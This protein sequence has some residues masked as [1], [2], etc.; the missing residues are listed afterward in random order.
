MTH[1]PAPLRTRFARATTQLERVVAQYREAFG[2]L[3]IGS[4]EDH[5]GI[6]GVILAFPGETTQYEW[7]ATQKDPSQGQPHPD[8]LLVWYFEHQVDLD[9]WAENALA[10][11]FREVM[12]HNPYWDRWGRTLEDVDGYRVVLALPPR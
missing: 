4:F 3:E 8:D 11:G 2:L 10:V 1:S 7:T 5:E 6:D 9:R 12:A